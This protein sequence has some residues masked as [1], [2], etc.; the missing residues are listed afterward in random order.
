[1]A[2]RG[3]RTRVTD[4]LHS[5]TRCAVS[6][7][8]SPWAATLRAARNL[9][10]GRVP[11]RHMQ[12]G[13]WRTT[14]A[15]RLTSSAPSPSEPLG[16][17]AAPPPASPPVGLALGGLPSEA[18]RMSAS[19]RVASPG[20]VRLG[21]WLLRAETREPPG[22]PATT[23][24]CHHKPAGRPSQPYTFIHGFLCFLHLH[25]G[26]DDPVLRLR[27]TRQGQHC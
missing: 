27:V 14:S 6:A 19:A 15:V 9:P 13:K 1:V 3:A 7:R 26:I 16:P 4:A 2:R 5:H 10:Q 25:L 21:Q 17:A 24:K 23:H 20:G 11:V 18:R 22:T 12:Y 8:P